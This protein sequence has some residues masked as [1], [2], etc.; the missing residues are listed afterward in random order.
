MTVIAAPGPTPGWSALAAGASLAREVGHLV[1]R[2]K[3]VELRD[4]V[5]RVEEL[6]LALLPLRALDPDRVALGAVDLHEPALPLVDDDLPLAG[7]GRV[8]PHDSVVE[9]DLGVHLV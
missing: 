7:Y 4:R 2:R 3:R 6:G 1:R 9:P 8:P 5:A